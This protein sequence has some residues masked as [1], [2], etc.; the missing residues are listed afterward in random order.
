MERGDLKFSDYNKMVALFH[1]ESDRG[2]AVLAAGYVDAVLSDYIEFRLKD[3]SISKELFD[4]NGPLATF[5]QRKNCSRI[6]TYPPPYSAEA[7]I[8]KESTKP[9]C[10]PPAER[11]L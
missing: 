7:G 1:E 11:L 10:A 6:W 8:H 2:A 3:K 5:S 4:A 9:F